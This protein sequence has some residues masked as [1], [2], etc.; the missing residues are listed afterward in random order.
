MSLL[1]TVRTAKITD[2]TFI[3]SASNQVINLPVL[4]L[5]EFILGHFW[6]LASL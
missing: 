1:S 5:P 2:R 6:L 4:T 3:V